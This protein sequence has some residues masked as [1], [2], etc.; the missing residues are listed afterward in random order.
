MLQ[1]AKEALNASDSAELQKL[2]S[3]IDSKETFS[4]KVDTAQ[5]LWKNKGGKKGKATFDSIKDTLTLMCV[6]VEV[7]NYCESNEATD[8]EHVHPKAFFP[9]FT[10]QWKNYILACK[11]CN[12]GYKSDKCFVITSDENVLELQRTTEPPHKNIAFINPREDNPLDFLWLNLETGEF[13]LQLDLTPVMKHKA[14]K[15]LEILGLNERD[16]LVAGRKSAAIHFFDTMDR[17][18]RI[19]QAETHEDI[20]EA[21]NP[22]S[23]RDID[24]TNTIEA[25][26]LQEV[27]RVRQHLLKQPHPSV[28][29]SIKTI[30]SKTDSRW[31][32]IFAAIPD[33]LEW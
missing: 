33:A 19:W 13:E 3:N 10:F 21:L 18:R 11:T 31:E 23:T 5:K 29:Y 28:W 7:C 2:Q 30:A 22:H 27:I 15:T 12:T 24:F 25:I 14:R 8:I 17:L 32:R 16:Y 1:L 6:A 4:Q 9:E 26:K 20:R